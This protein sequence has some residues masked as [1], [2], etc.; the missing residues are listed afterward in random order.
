M[1]FGDD[2]LRAR[3]NTAA[4]LDKMMRLNSATLP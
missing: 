4:F 2:L 3:G 1:P